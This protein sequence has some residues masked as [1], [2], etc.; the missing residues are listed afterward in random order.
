MDK[1]N[2]VY[3]KA[4]NIYIDNKSNYNFII[5]PRN[6]FKTTKYNLSKYCEIKLYLV[7]NI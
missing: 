6:K 1:Y 2:K 4:L 3:Q 5:L 7:L